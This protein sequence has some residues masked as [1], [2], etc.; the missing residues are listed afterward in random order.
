MQRVVSGVAV[1]CA[2]AAMLL[3]PAAAAAQERASIVGVVQ[4]ATDAVMPGVT[5]E[6]SSPALIE[7]VRSAVTDGV[8][9]LRHHRSPS[10]HLHRHVHAP[11]FPIRQARGH[12]A[13]RRVRRAG[14]RGARRRTGRGNRDRHRRIARRRHAEHA[15]PGGPQPRRCSTCCRPRAR[16]RAAPAWCPAS[17]STARASPARCRSTARRPR[18]AHLLRWH[19]HRAEPDAAGAARRTASRVNELAQTELVY[20]AG[21]QS[22]E[23]A[24]GGVRMDSIPKE[25]GNSF[26][27]V[28]RFFGVERDRCRT[29]TSRRN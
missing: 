15:E 17:A 12:R 3:L 13:R 20:D 9:P 27:G 7:Q 18:S 16:C 14:E 21:S 19:E 1:A 10:R 6:A 8:R 26:S 22:A 28:A 2:C 24:L 29:T 11:R 4:D 5:V 23:N 25:G